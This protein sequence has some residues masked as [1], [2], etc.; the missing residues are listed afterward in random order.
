MNENKKIM[1]AQELLE[2]RQSVTVNEVIAMFQGEQNYK[3]TECAFIAV[4]ISD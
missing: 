4:H 1:T 2:S 3:V